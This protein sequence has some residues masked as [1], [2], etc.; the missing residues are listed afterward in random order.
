MDQDGSQVGITSTGDALMMARER[1]LDLVEVAPNAS[2]PVC[3]IMDFGKYKYQLEISEKE[4]RKKQ[5]QII[6]KEIKLRPKID[7][8]DLSIKKKQIENFLKKGS[9]VKITLSF[10][11][12][13][14]I[15]SEL[16]MN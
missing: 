6:I 5:T 10:K 2:P 3:R 7:K 9:K 15:H 14:I 13:E 4:K 8:N 1:D 12:R 11:G 16:G